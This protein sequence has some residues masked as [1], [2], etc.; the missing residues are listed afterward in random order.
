MQQEDYLMRQFNLLGR[1]LGKMLADLLGLDSDVLVNDG[2]EITK[3]TLKTQLDLDIDELCALR[4]DDFI[5]ILLTEKK[6]DNGNLGQLAE[7]FYVLAENS[8][9]TSPMRIALYE[10][11]L[12]IYEYL[13]KHETTYSFE[14]NGIIMRIK[15]ILS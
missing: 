6:L 11:C 12:A 15:S 9:D 8:E 13:D 3:K 2:L 14:R 5:N 4:T 1:V 10:K 7:I